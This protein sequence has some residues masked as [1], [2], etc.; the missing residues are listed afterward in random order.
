M[1]R[2]NKSLLSRRRQ[3]LTSG[4]CSVRSRQLL[5]FTRQAVAPAKAVPC[6]CPPAGNL[7]QH[8]AAL[9]GRIRDFRTRPYGRRPITHRK[10]IIFASIERVAGPRARTN[11]S[12]PHPPDPNQILTPTACALHIGGNCSLAHAGSSLPKAMACI[13]HPPSANEDEHPAEN[14]GTGDFR[15]T[16]RLT[17]TASTTAKNLFTFA[18]KER[19]TRHGRP[20]S[21]DVFGSR[22]RMRAP[23]KKVFRPKWGGTRAS[24]ESR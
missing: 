4:V 16:V 1:I 17:K 11:R 21:V 6:P 13:P 14:G 2:A 24:R 8:L 12:A 9:N 20:P 10:R 5:A 22:G 15:T 7:L 19:A 23:E 18:T 3:S